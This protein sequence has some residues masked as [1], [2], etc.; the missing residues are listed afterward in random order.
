MDGRI[1]MVFDCRKINQHF[2]NP[3][4]VELR[5]ASG[6]AEIEVVPEQPVYYTALDVSNAFY[7][8]SIPQWRGELFCLR[9][10]LAH[11]VGILSLDGAFVASHV[12]LV[13]LM[14]RWSRWA[15]RGLFIWFSMLMSPCWTWLHNWMLVGEPRTSFLFPSLR[16]ARCIVSTWTMC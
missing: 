14:P 16:R 12:H 6:Y 3:P 10:A 5:S 13:S 11:E 2:I 7:Q 4:H 9:S 8:H 15:G 1:R